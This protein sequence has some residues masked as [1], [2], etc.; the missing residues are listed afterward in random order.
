VTE[1]RSVI[2]REHDVSRAENVFAVE[3]GQ[4]EWSSS[5]SRIDLARRA[6]AG[7][8][9]Q[10]SRM[11]SAIAEARNLEGRRSRLEEKS[12][13][14]VL[15]ALNQELTLAGNLVA[16]LTERS[17]QLDRS[18]RAAEQDDTIAAAYALLLQSGETI[19][20]SNG[21][22]P[23][24]SSKVS[25]IEFNAAVEAGRQALA[26]RKSLAAE[27]LKQMSDNVKTLADAKRNARALEVQRDS[28]AVERS[29]VDRE[30]VALQAIFSDLG[31]GTTVSVGTAEG[32]TSRYQEQTATLDGLL[33]ALESSSLQDKL[34]T[35]NLRTAERRQLVEDEAL[36]LAKAERVLERSKQIERSAKVVGNELLAEQLDTVLPLLKELYLRLRPHAEW[37]EIEIDVAGQVRASLNFS[38]G[39][40]KNPQFLFSS[41]QRRAAGLAFLLAIYLSR[42]WCGLKTL[43]LDDPVQHVD[44]YRALNLVEVLASIRSGREQVIVAVEDDALADLLCR[45]L[46]INSVEGGVRFNLAVDLTGSSH[47]EEEKPVAML[48]PRVFGMAE[49]S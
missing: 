24:C 43:M 33:G 2:Q 40:G 10:L 9:T 34:S 21:A 46:R 31:L 7:R 26:S 38:V 36:G 20:I 15:N 8:R 13:E 25:E 28:I 35:L 37:R 3:I 14:R 49:A 4:T 23:L 17:L 18:L 48:T 1:A 39:G 19:G 11:N 32:L 47:I 30:H 5:K 6:V 29:E 12:G 44:D 22:C 41:G 45:R 42:P 16:E 27:L